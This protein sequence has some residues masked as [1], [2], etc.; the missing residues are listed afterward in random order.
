[1]CPHC[2]VYSSAGA[3]LFESPNQKILKAFWVTPKS[4]KDLEFSFQLQSKPNY[5]ELGRGIGK[6]WGDDTILKL[7]CI[8]SPYKGKIV[9]YILKLVR[10]IKHKENVSGFFLDYLKL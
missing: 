2:L 5:M 6:G 9:I 1:M 7:E 10:R 8:L 3:I 4:L